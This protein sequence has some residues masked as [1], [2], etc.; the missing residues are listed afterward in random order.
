MLVLFCRVLRFGVISES[1][2]KC[3]GPILG[4]VILAFSLPRMQCPPSTKLYRWENIAELWI[5]QTASLLHH[6]QERSSCLW[7]SQFILQSLNIRIYCSSWG[8]TS[9]KSSINNC[10]VNSRLLTLSHVPHRSLQHTVSRY[11]SLLKMPKLKHPPK[12]GFVSV[13]PNYSLPNIGGMQFHG[14]T[15]ISLGMVDY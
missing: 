5:V 13:L 1:Q 2:G 10:N 7:S 6:F 15:V 3:S 11:W 14:V 4:R 12:E 9:F 8:L